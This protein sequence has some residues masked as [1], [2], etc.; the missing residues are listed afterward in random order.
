MGRCGEATWASCP[1]HVVLANLFFF[2]DER[3]FVGCLE[4]IC[5]QVF[6]PLCLLFFCCSFPLLVI[7]ISL[8]YLALFNPLFLGYNGTF[9]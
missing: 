5:Y 8:L 2:E 3:L 7:L 9:A 6:L 1:T 4:L